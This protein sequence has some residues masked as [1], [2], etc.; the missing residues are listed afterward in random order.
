MADGYT[1][2]GTPIVEHWIGQIARGKQFRSQFAHEPEWTTW[3]RWY[4]GEW[5]PKILPSN[6]YFKMMRT[7][8][9]RIYYRNP[10]VSLT[11]SKPGLENYLLCKLLERADNK[12]ID[13]MG[14]KG[15]M[16]RAVQH[17]CMFGTGGLR[18]GYGAEFTPTPDDIDTTDPDTGSA[19]VQ[20]KVEYN[21]L[22][23]PNMPWL[24]AAHPSTIIVP[25]GAP[26]I[27]SARWYCFETNRPADDVKSDPRYDSQ[28]RKLIQAGTSDGK[29]IA[30][31]Q[32][33]SAR[34]REGVVLWEIHDK[35]TG[36]V[37]VL[38]P[39]VA[40]TRIEGKVLYCEQDD[41]QINGRLNYYPLIFNNDD[42]VFWGIPDSQIIAPQQGEKNEVR[43]Q[44]RNHRRIAIAKLLYEKGSVDPD[45]MSKLIDG[46]AN[47]AVMVKNIA[48]VQ[49]LNMGSVAQVL[50]ILERVESIVD[51]DVEQL[52]G[53][54]VNQ[55]GEYAPGS[56]DRSATEAN[57]VNQATAIRVD[58]RRDAC[59]DLL[60]DVISDMNH[61][62]I[63][64]WDSEMV[65]D[66]VGPAG[67][68][69]WI[70]VQPHAMREALYDT[71]IDPDTSLPLTKA[72][73]EQKAVQIYGILKTNPLVNPVHLTQFLVGEMYGTDADFLLQQPLFNTSPKNPMQLGEAASAMG[74]LP[75]PDMGKLQ[76]MLAAPAQV[77]PPQLQT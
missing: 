58:E 3:R 11:P 51:L 8:I 43:T 21:D 15:Q 4:R 18:L 42:E 40:D 74:Q 23:H 70:A 16:K 17:A 32:P 67:V 38:A 22:V 61:T 49:E 31:T 53:L 66:I 56:A 77:I 25:H 68:P 47:G 50:Q 24:L 55:F 30:R 72:L 75:Q 48:G 35:K 60:V 46:N 34:D 14:L 13:I 1:K 64:R 44:I 52:L 7:L 5:N 37:F 57:I 36:L 33:K 76:Q 63:E 20:K 71:K 27:H 12:L 69:I 10:S 6:V 65:L 59:A 19:R 54:G 29:L 41:L 45:E 28:A 62:I 2:Q 26:D 9:P 39:H 73:R